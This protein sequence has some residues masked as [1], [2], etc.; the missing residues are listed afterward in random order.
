[1]NWARNFFL[2]DLLCAS[3]FLDKSH[4]CST[5][6]TLLPAALF[7]GAGFSVEYFFGECDYVVGGRL[8][9]FVI[10]VRITN[11]RRCLVCCVYLF[12]LGHTSQ[13]HLEGSHPKMCV[14]QPE[15]ALVHICRGGV[16]FHICTPATRG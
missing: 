6:D 4:L 15:H 11:S 7:K 8:F 2:D 12:F 16:L 13:W 14:S 10:R 9:V 5:L 1:L 3:R